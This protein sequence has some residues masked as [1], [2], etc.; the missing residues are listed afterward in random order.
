MDNREL[1]TDKSEDYVRFRP[2]YPTESVAW[3]RARCEDVTVV[4]VGAGTGIFTACLKPYFSNILAVE[5][6]R[7]MRQKF[8]QL[9]PDISCLDSC[10]EATGLPASSAFSPPQATR[11]KH[12]ARARISANSFFI[13][14]SSL[15]FM[16][17]RAFV[18][19]EAPVNLFQ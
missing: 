6:K 14:C 1:F 4:D 9:L 7:D 11:E 8:V 2:S 5:P 13:W 17:G 10:G 3:M 18:D 15:L 16:V 12:I 19:F